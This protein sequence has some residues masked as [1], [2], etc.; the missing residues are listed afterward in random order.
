MWNG[1][2]RMC[3]ILAGE[4]SPLQFRPA[5]AGSKCTQPSQFHCRRAEPNLAQND[6][7]TTTSRR[8]P[9][10]ALLAVRADLRTPIRGETLD[11]D[12]NASEARTIHERDPES[13][14]GDTVKSEANTRPLTREERVALER[15]RLVDAISSGRTDRLLER[16]AWVLSRHPA[17]RDSDIALQ[18]VYWQEYEPELYVKLEDDPKVLYQL[19]RL[20]SISRARARIQNTHRLFVASDK[21]R[22]RR[23]TL[24]EEERERFMNP[25]PPDPLL[26]VYAD[27][28]GKTDAHLVV[29]SVWFLDP[30]DTVTAYNRISA[31]RRERG[32]EEELH[33][34]KLSQRTLGYYQEVVEL[35]L[36]SVAGLSFKSVSVSRAGVANVA[37][38]LDH[39]FVELL[40]RGVEHEHTTGRAPL[41]RRL[42]VYKDLEEPGRDALLMA[43][44][45]T[46]L[47]TASATEFNGELRVEVLEPVRS[48]GQPLIQI[49][50]LYT[51]SVNR[52]LARAAT[53]AKA[54]DVF[55]DY[56][57]GRVRGPTAVTA[58]EQVG[59]MEVHLRL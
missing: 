2:L 21:V 20:T 3:G 58:T 47:L 23:G 56:F 27:E 53:S 55:A 17:T 42:T 59:D 57:L 1:A 5:R 10:L 22:R 32:F 29:G 6:R 14:E 44:M 7:A 25:V 35:L 12:N 40:R 9:K 34:S 8:L 48:D 51:A 30:S 41:P 4:R 50:D 49:A 45:R 13:P 52:V 19:T 28:S 36:G 18:L 16:V 39:L 33:F 26:M 15:Q 54:K 24:S 11:S 46:A 31:W 43:R 38:A 37:E